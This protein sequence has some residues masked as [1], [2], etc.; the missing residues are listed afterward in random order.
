MNNFDEIVK[1]GEN[2]GCLEA[3]IEEKYQLIKDAVQ[4]IK[5]GG[6]TL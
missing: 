6:E 3:T 5:I 1:V 2:L 4:I